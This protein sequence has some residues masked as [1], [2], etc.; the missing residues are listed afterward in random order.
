MV[1]KENRALNLRSANAN[2]SVPRGSIAS[3]QGRGYCPPMRA[4][5][6]ACLRLG[7]VATISLLLAFVVMMFLVEAPQVGRWFAASAVVA[8]ASYVTALVA[9]HFEH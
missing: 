8:L 9:A 2:R 4:I 3:G 6:R 1:A 5:K 7:V